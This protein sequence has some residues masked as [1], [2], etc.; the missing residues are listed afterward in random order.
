MFPVIDIGPIAIQAAG[1]ILLLS[2]MIG[3]FLTGKF[4]GAIRTNGETIENCILIGLISGIIGARVGFMLQNPSVFLDNPFSTLSLTPSMLN[5]SFG[6]LV[7]G[8]AIFIVAQNKHLPFW[9]TLDTLSPLIILLFGGIHL[10]NLA[11]GNVYGLPTDLPWGI[12]L[13]NANRHPVQLYSLILIVGLF[14]WLLIHTKGFKTTGY[15]RSGVLFCFTIAGIAFSTVITRAFIA[16]KILLAGVDLI[17]IL[18]LLTHSG[19]FAILYKR[20]FSPRRNIDVFISIGSNLNPLQNLPAALERL[21]EDFKIQRTSSRYWTKDVKGKSA[22][23]LNQVIEIETERSY[24]ELITKL[25]DIEKEFGRKPGNKQEVAL[26]LDVLT[27]NEDVFAA[28]GK[29][30]PDPNLQ[31]YRYIAEPLAEIAPN[32]RHP[33]NGQSIQM[34]LNNM[35]DDSQIALHKEVENGTKK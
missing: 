8:L 25:K 2:L 15:M 6:L 22:N 33:A 28:Q 11:N 23:F 31:K 24:A 5:A 20:S 3:L 4:S 30:I 29:L 35:K 34:I 7:A 21:G 10:A 18:A 32:F 16:E 26:D 9:P 14:L 12:R 1:L 19:S 17:Q 27:Y 13:W